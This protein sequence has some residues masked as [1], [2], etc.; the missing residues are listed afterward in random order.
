MANNVNRVTMTGNLT[1]D[2]ELYTTPSGFA[3]CTLRLAVNTSHKMADGTWG[4]KPNYF[5]VK[6]MG[7]QGE[8]V[9]K[10]LSKGRKVALDGHLEWREWETQDGSKRQAVEIIVGMNDTIEFLS[11]PGEGR[12]SSNGG[13]EHYAAEEAL[14]PASGGDDIPF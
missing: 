9:S 11:S 6:V 8:N 12:A 1:K 2:P 13:S 14:A 5:D 7:K 3:I 10:F 4:D